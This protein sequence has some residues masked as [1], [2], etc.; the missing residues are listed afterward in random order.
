M[1]NFKID[2]GETNDETIL[3]LGV[4]RSFSII[5]KLF[6]SKHIFEKKEFRFMYL[7]SMVLLYTLFKQTRHVGKIH[8]IKLKKREWDI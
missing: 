5:Q 1:Y 7:K 3:F 6:C 4:C 2:V 8:I